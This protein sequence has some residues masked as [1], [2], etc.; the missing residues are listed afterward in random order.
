M[1]GRG[2][3]RVNCSQAAQGVSGSRGLRALRHSRR[4]YFSFQARHPS[5]GP[6]GWILPL[7]GHYGS[8]GR[9]QRAEAACQMLPDR[10]T[11]SQTRHNP[12]PTGRNLPS[13]TYRRLAAL[14]GKPPSIIQLGVVLEP[15]PTPRGQPGGVAPGRG[16]VRAR[17][18][19]DAD[20]PGRLA[21]A[22][23]GYAGRARGAVRRRRAGP[24]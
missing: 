18:H 13:G 11:P 4:N 8:I 5:L 6:E 2:G 19:L 3:G 14:L 17:I 9:L 10:S 22:T 15:R 20:F 24:I 21:K 1:V 16:A 7:D 12:S 23:G